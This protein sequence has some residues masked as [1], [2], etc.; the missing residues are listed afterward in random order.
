MTT[1]KY[2]QD[3]LPE[4]FRALADNKPEDVEAFLKWCQLCKA[5]LIVFQDDDERECSW[6]ELHEHAALLVRKSRG[7]AERLLMQHM[8]IRLEDLRTKC[9]NDALWRFDTCIEWCETYLESEKA[10]ND[11]STNSL[12]KEFVERD[13]ASDGKQIIASYAK[14][15][16][17]MTNDATGKAKFIAFYS[18]PETGKRIA[19]TSGI[20]LIMRRKSRLY[21]LLDLFAKSNSGVEVSEQAV[22]SGFGIK[23]PA[24]D[25][26]IDRSKYDTDEDHDHYC[27]QN[28]QSESDETSMLENLSSNYTNED[29]DYENAE[30]S[31]SNGAGRE[32]SY[33]GANL[34]ECIP[35]Q[36]SPARIELS[37]LT[38]DL[39]RK[40]RDK[41]PYKTADNQSLIFSIAKSEAVTSEIVVRVLSRDDNRYYQFG[42]L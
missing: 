20:P 7:S 4:E 9:V 17:G 8:D 27:R 6:K 36:V 35:T 39:S 30:L 22:M 3:Q 16:I 41:L 40:L 32:A 31:I 19:I 29:Y 12:Q 25:S 5:Q 1:A 28:G 14:I 10:K 26:G 11:T 37:R 42:E 33:P 13:D 15:G 23:K 2:G 24:A 21:D 38:S 34:Q 18:P